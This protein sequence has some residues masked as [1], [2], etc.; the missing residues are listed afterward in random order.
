MKLDPSV[1]RNV[2]FDTDQAASIDMTQVPFDD[3]KIIIR[4]KPDSYYISS[5]QLRTGDVVRV[6]ER[7]GKFSATA[8]NN[9][10]VRN[11]VVVRRSE[12]A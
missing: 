8:T 2:L 4:Y 1:W 9:G 3:S 6:V 10:E 11:L 12:T 7:Y 5:D